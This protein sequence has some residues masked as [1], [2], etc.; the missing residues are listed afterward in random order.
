MA[1]KFEIT[2]PED[3]KRSEQFKKWGVYSGVSLLVLWL[4]WSLFGSM[5]FDTIPPKILIMY[6]ETGSSTANS[7]LI[8]TF[9]VVD[10][11]EIDYC[12]LYFNNERK[13]NLSVKRI[14]IQKQ[15][16][17]LKRIGENSVWLECVDSSLASNKGKSPLITFTYA[18][19]MSTNEIIKAE[20]SDLKEGLISLYSG[21]EKGNKG[22]E[23]IQIL[24][25]GAG[26]EFISKNFTSG[27]ISVG[28]WGKTN[29]R[30]QVVN[31]TTN[32]ETKKI[33]LPNITGITNNL[34]FYVA[35]DGSTYHSLSNHDYNTSTNGNI[36]LPD[37]NWQEALNAKHLARSAQ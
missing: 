6:P 17:N 28:F 3:R 2:S 22:K 23:I 25:R 27:I 15:T 13:S 1:L 32:T 21:T 12:D 10:E 11:S 31:V 30:E 19:P 20:A 26:S 35:S 5:F 37:L 36:T 7:S 34:I 24:P 33:F 29:L 16:L 4:G 9:T 18:E 8:V 14:E